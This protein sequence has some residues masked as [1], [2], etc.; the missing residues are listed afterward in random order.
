[1]RVPVLADEFHELRTEFLALGD[2]GL[3]KWIF[4]LPK[5]LWAGLLT[6][7]ASVIALP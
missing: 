2:A 5:K 4:R 7:H 1:M 3:G 6:F